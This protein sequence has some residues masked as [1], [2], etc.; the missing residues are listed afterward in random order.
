LFNLNSNETVN[1]MSSVEYKI[2]DHVNNN[3]VSSRDGPTAM[4]HHKDEYMEDPLPDLIG[5]LRIAEEPEP[6]LTSTDFV[7]EDF[8]FSVNTSSDE[9]DF[10]DEQVSSG[11]DLEFFDISSSVGSC[12]NFI[13]HPTA[14]AEESESVELDLGTGSGDE[15]KGAGGSES[16]PRTKLGDAKAKVKRIA[17]SVKEL[18]GKRRKLRNIR[19]MYH[20]FDKPYTARVSASH[21]K[22]FLTLGPGQGSGRFT[23]K[24]LCVTPS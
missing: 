23:T 4:H 21:F 20:N 14:A 11:S 7:L 12:L 18:V 2:E 16:G 15:G 10:E 17:A 6:D 9:E 13:D 1:K 22:K 24:I 19:V 8:E 5:S 3:E